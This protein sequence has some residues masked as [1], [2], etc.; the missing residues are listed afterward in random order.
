MKKPFAIT[1]SFE[2]EKEGARDFGSFNLKF[3]R[4]TG[5]RAKSACEGLMAWLAKQQLS[6]QERKQFMADFRDVLGRFLEKLGAA[7]EEK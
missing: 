3:L 7:N 4:F 2:L 6:D 1:C 5:T